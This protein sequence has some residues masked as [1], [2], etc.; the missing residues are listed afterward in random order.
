[1]VRWLL[2]KLNGS[3]ALAR[4]QYA[5]LLLSSTKVREK[6]KEKGISTVLESTYRQANDT[7]AACKKE[8]FHSR[9]RLVKALFSFFF[10][11][12][13]LKALLLQHCRSQNRFT[14]LETDHTLVS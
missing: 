10:P 14:V 4:W 2:A 8:L 12:A 5:G 13:E 3:T 6:E 11:M 7:T 9:E 1:V